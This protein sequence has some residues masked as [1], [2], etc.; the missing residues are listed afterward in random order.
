MAGGGGGGA[1]VVVLK[2]VFQNNKVIAKTLGFA[3]TLGLW[4]K[5]R[6]KS[7]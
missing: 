5:L 4:T 7:G 6:G 3:K 1:V 2:R